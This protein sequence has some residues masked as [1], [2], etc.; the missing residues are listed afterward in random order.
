LPPVTGEPVSAAEFAA[1]I[2]PL[3]PFEPQP[4]VAVAVSGGADSLAAGLLT[5]DWARSR[6]GEVLALV[7]DH[8]LRAES[9]GE[10][11][12]TCSRL[13][14]A[15]VPSVLLTLDNVRHGPGLAARART[16]RHA[17]LE[18]QCARR[19]ILHLVFGH[20]AGDQAETV[21]MRML[22]QS[23]AT[24]LA[25]MA[26]LTETQRVRRLR[27]LLGISPLRLRATVAGEGLSWV[28]DPSNADPAH[29][30]A[31]LREL[32]CDP[33][34]TG[35]A[36]RGL[37]TAAIH[38]G[39]ARAAAEVEWA[40]ELAQRVMIFPQGYALLSPGAIAPEALAALLAMLSGAAIPP[41]LAQVT[42]LAA[43]MAPATVAGIRILKAGRLGEGFLLAREPAACAAPVPAGPGAVWDGRFRVVRA[44]G[45]P[46]LTLGAWGA[47][48]VGDRRGLPISVLRSLPV[49]RRNGAVVR[50]AT[51][52]LGADA[53]CIIFSPG[54]PASAARFLPSGAF[55]G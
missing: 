24:G 21:V 33:A 47:D 13:A 36:T 1:A 51:E 3:G 49:L 40:G 29:L 11:R 28:E 44:V 18:A 26:A 37:V 55:S 32:R 5:R 9:A 6:R 30:R 41:P 42:K 23:H 31:R 10:A 22:A 34:G 14:T 15:G 4:R 8:G 17:A 54:R 53:P 38:R 35:A 27:P 52:L 12:L 2:E 46:G 19:G 20:H 25:G 45:E 48:P 7:V 50:D 16:A 43:E 39:E